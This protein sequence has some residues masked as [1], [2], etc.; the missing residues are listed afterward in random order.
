MPFAASRPATNSRIPT[1]SS[2]WRRTRRRVR[3]S[4]CARRIWRDGALIFDGEPDGRSLSSRRTDPG[5]RVASGTSSSL[6]DQI[7]PAGTCFGFTVTDKIQA[8]H[9]A[10]I[11]GFRS[12]A[13]NMTQSSLYL[14]PRD[15]ILQAMERIYRY[16]M[17]TTSGGNLSIREA[18]GD[19]W[20]TPAR[21]DKG[22]SAPR[23]HRV[24]ARRR[25][26]SRARA[27]LPP[28][29]PSTADPRAPARYRRHRAR[30]SGGAGGVQPGAPG[31]GYAALPPGAPRLRRGGFAP[32]ELPGSVAL[33]ATWPRLS[34]RASTA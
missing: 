26:A 17:T 30:A 6:N 13:I 3:A 28:S 11:D 31:P 24:R 19:V 7:R 5:R 14:H 27:A 25:R 12:S 29:C 22:G 34:R 33:G 2:M 32:Y 18:N 15:E 21:I 9:G 20:I 10:Q 8:A 16:R 4:K 23:G 1:I